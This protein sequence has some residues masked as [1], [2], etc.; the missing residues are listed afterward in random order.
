MQLR[1]LEGP[2]ISTAV[3]AKDQRRIEKTQLAFSPG[4]RGQIATSFD[5]DR[6]WWSRWVCLQSKRLVM[7]TYCASGHHPHSNVEH[8]SERLQD[9]PSSRLKKRS[10]PVF[11]GGGSQRPRATWQV[12]VHPLAQRGVLLLHAH[13]YRQLHGAPRHHRLPGLG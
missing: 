1:R 3:Y 5:G 2:F 9:V 7:L 13:H 4:A 8:A 11:A 6:L 12:V 10:K